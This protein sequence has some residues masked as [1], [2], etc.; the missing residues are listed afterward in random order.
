MNNKIKVEF[1][2]PEGQSHFMLYRWSETELTG[3]DEDRPRARHRREGAMIGSDGTVR[4]I[5]YGY[6]AIGVYTEGWTDEPSQKPTE[7]SSLWQVRCTVA[8]NGHVGCTI[9][10]KV[11]DLY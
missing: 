1:V 11:D 8:I 2:I 9:P 7:K 4:T 3:A 6:K 10:Q 5:P